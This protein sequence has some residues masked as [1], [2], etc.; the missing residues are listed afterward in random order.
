MVHH[1]FCSK[2]IAGWGNSFRRVFEQ[3]AWDKNDAS[4][5]FQAWTGIYIFCRFSE[6][7]FYFILLLD[8]R[9]TY[10]F[11]IYSAEVSVFLGGNKPSR[12]GPVRGDISIK[13]SCDPG[14]SSKLVYTLSQSTIFYFVFISKFSWQIFVIL[15]FLKGWSCFEWN[16]TSSRRRAYR[17][18]CFVNPR[19]WAEGSWKWTAG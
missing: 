7:L 17:S 14:I 18:R 19:D 11:Q 9:F 16:T 2:Q 3:I 10:L 15:K 12:I 8:S 13:F 6:Y 1:V 5:A 4:S